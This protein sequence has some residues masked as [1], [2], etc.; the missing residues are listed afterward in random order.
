MQKIIEKHPIGFSWLMLLIQIFLGMGFFLFY[1]IFNFGKQLPLGFHNYDIYNLFYTIVAVAIVAL[2]GWWRE[3]GFFRL[4]N[5]RDY[6]FYILP[7]GIACIILSPGVSPSAFRDNFALSSIVFY[8]IL[9]AREEV[10]SRG[11]IQHALSKRGEIYA[12]FLSAVFFGLI[13]TST[14]FVGRAFPGDTILQVSRAIAFGVG[15]AGLRLRTRSIYPL[16]ILHTLLNIFTF[17]TEASLADMPWFSSSWYSALTPFLQRLIVFELPGYLFCLYG[18][19]LVISSPSHSRSAGRAILLGHLII[20]IPV[21]MII[22]G[23]A[24]GGLIISLKFALIFLVIGFILAWL[25]WAFMVPRWRQW[26]LDQEVP[27]E[28]LQSLA[29]VT[30]LVWPKGSI[31]ERTEFKLNKKNEVE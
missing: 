15:F 19:Y 17:T 20:S 6:L 29:V 3:V 28:R 24:I 26:A 18:F 8:F 2:L 14:L 10:F 30:G 12:I 11:L 23:F 31:F 1:R 16:I 9:S 5:W 27:A 4:E 21:L 13:H 7:L 25:W 22:I